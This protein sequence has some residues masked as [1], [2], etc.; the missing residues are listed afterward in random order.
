MFT[1]LAAGFPADRMVM[2]GNNKL[3]SELKMAV[4][5]GIGRIAID[6]L[7][8]IGRVGALARAAGRRQGVY[9]RVTPGVTADT[10][11]HIQT[12]HHES[13]FGLPLQGGVAREASSVP[14]PTPTS[15]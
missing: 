1:G 8:E 2:H 11:V 13:K 14:M 3:D 4:D 7:E 15:N 5:A 9:L 12:G 10:H 6:N